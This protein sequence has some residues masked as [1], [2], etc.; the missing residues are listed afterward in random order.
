MSGFAEPLLDLDFLITEQDTVSL[1]HLRTYLGNPPVTEQLSDYSDYYVTLQDERG[2][3]LTRKDVPVSFL[4]LDPTE[5]VSETPASV[6][7]L[8]Q[9]AVEEV[10][11]FH[12][13][14]LL[15]QQNLRFLCQEDGQCSP[16][17]NYATCPADCPSGSSD[18]YC[19]RVTDGRCDPDCLVE[20]DC[21]RST[22]SPWLGALLLLVSVIIIFLLWRHEQWR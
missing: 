10:N 5:K 13:P 6:T 9:P 20:E 11:V 7:V 4:L 17:E 21:A 2:E 12:G 1:Y 22:F 14:K 19:D 15:Y 8:Y 3:I 18:N 16:P